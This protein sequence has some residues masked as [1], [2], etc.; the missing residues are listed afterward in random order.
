MNLN[1][2]TACSFFLRSTSGGIPAREKLQWIKPDALDNK[3]NGNIKPPYIN[4]YFILFIFFAGTPAYIHEA[5]QSLKTT[6]LAA[7]IQLS[8]MYTS[9]EITAPVYIVTLLPTEGMPFL[10]AP[11]ITL[12]YTVK[13]LPIILQLR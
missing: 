1:P 10:A 13:F 6:E 5:S 3:F 2:L 11:N 4:S 12:G 7:I 8:P 9:P